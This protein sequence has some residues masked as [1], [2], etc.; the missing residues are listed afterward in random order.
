MILNA[1]DEIR[2]HSDPILNP[3]ILPEVKDFINLKYCDNINSGASS[4]PVISDSLS[5][6][7]GRLS[8]LIPISMCGVV[9]VALNL[10]CKYVWSNL[11]CCRLLHSQAQGYKISSDKARGACFGPFLHSV[12]CN[13]CVTFS[14]DGMLSI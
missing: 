13:L 9:G 3:F 7:L 10:S 14:A 6:F 4:E 1:S 5:Q 11:N 12:L 2:Y 8:Y